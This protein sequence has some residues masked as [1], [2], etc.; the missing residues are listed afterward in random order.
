VHFFGKG[1]GKAVGQ[2]FGHNAVV[3]VM[4]GLKLGHHLVATNTGCYSKA[5]PK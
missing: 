4:I 1:F 2:G 3:I 5:T